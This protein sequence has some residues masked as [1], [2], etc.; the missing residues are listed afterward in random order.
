MIA[1]RV[2]M[3]TKYIENK[4]VSILTVEEV[5]FDFYLRQLVTINH[6]SWIQDTC[7]LN[8]DIQTIINAS[9]TKQNRFWIES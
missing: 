8:H 2:Y 5:T 4:F 3:L 1:L 9:N 6:W 7:L